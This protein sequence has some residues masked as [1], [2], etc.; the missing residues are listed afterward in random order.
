MAY[1]FPPEHERRIRFSPEPQPQPQPEPESWRPRAGRI[2]TPAPK[3]EERRKSRPSFA[4]ID[5]V[6]ADMSHD[7]RVEPDE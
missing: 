1:R 3:S 7:A 6:E 5:V 4:E 2:E